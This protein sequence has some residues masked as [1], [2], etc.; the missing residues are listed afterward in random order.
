MLFFSVDSGLRQD[1]ISIWTALLVDAQVLFAYSDVQES[2]GSGLSREDS[3]T[4]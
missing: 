3:G 4:V 1:R 2:R